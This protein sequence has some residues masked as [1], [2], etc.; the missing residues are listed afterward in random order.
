MEDP[1]PEPVITFI[2][3]NLAKPGYK[4]QHIGESEKCKV[5]KIYNVCIQP[6]EVERIYEVVEVLENEFECPIHEEQ[7]KVVRVRETKKE[8]GIPSSMTFS[9]ATISFQP[10]DCHEICESRKFCV[11]AGLKEGDKVRIIDTIEKVKCRE[12]KEISLA[13]VARIPQDRS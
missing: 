10:Q 8:V 3:K 7:I 2:A 4:F 11:P 6:L 5:C 9:G 12:G 13:L 1:E